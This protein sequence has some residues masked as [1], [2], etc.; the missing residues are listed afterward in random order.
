MNMPPLAFDALFSL[1]KVQPRFYSSN[2]LSG[3][4]L[5]SLYGKKYP[6]P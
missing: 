4:F 2:I 1:I 5:P 6:A 3:V